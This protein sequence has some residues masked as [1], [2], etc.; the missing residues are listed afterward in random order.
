MVITTKGIIVIMAAGYLSIN[1][2]INGVKK[3]VNKMDKK[4]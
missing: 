2:I 1:A 4:E 3:L